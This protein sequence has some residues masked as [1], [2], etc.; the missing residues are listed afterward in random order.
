MLG[1]VHMNSDFKALSLGDS[2]QAPQ[3]PASLLGSWLTPGR[4][5]LILAGLIAAFFPDVLFAGKSF[6]F[7]DFG[8][9]TYPLAHYQRES[10]W[11]GE[12]PLWDPL[13]NCGIPFLAQWNTMVLYPLSLIYILLPL[14][15]GLNIYLLIHLVLAGMGMF[16][17]ASHWTKNRLAAGVAG[18][19]F[20]F[21]GLTL[22]C[23]MWTS[24]IAALAWMPWVV[25]ACEQAGQAG[26]RKQVIIAAL[27]GA[28]QM[29]TG[30][31]EIILFTWF[32]LFALWIGQT[33]QS[34]KLRL[35]FPTRLALIILLVSLLGAAQLLPFLD[36]I[37]HS[38]RNR[39]M[40]AD[41][42]AIPLSGWANL[43]VP[44]FN[45]YKSPLGVYFQ[46]GQ[47]WTSS[48]YL[49]VGTLALG[50]LAIFLVRVPR[51]WL[52]SAVAV[53]GFIVAM[54]ERG[55][56]YPWLLKIFPP[57]GFMRYPVKF[58]LL[59]SFTT[60]LLAAFAIARLGDSSTVRWSTSV[61]WTMSLAMLLVFTMGALVWYAH[62]YPLTNEPWKTVWI[63]GLTRVIFLVLILAT[64]LVYGRIQQLRLQIIMGLLLLTLVWLDVATHA[65]R[66]NPTVE[67]SVY[68]PGLLS[69]QLHVSPG[70]GDGRAFLEKQT[71]DLVYGWM[72]LDP[73]KD[74]LGRRVVLLGDCNLLD[75]I[76]TLAGFFPVYLREPQ[77]IFLD[78]F[79]AA[80]NNFPSGLADF[81]SVSQVT[82]PRRLSDWQFRS[83]HLPFCTMGQKPIFVALSNTPALLLKPDFDPR[84]IVYL[85]PEARTF[86]RATNQTHGSIRSA[87]YTA[88]RL[89]F[90][91]AA[92]APALLVLS[93][94]YYHPWR[95]YLD[96]KPTQIWQ[97]DYAFQALEVP[98][99]SHRVK[100][101]YEDRQF[102]LGVII[103]LT[104]LTGCLI[105][106]CL[107]PRT[108]T[109]P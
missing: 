38:D 14:T 82:N 41:F 59:T 40:G 28:L 90:E 63:N 61:R 15:W 85:P 49:G 102:Y 62:V 43:L 36:L 76:P 20:V 3:L 75:D 52:L 96:D 33:V 89:D 16:L 30:S 103:S 99:G 37:A 48:Y 60:P 2:E 88:H 51:V 12:V 93:Q 42:W 4:F 47:D 23:L 25:L 109:T 54:G 86:V 46:P 19:A 35:R 69:R 17:L 105:F 98:G 106:L 13:N 92:N 84:Q 81:L 53:F 68:Q 97:A 64:V 80:T 5:A 31:P 95:A 79:N 91:V 55:E 74:Y 21:N 34:G 108:T 104:T 101:V 56:L 50:L 66:Q 39:A 29:F 73:Y 57:L 7:R 94:A 26:E 67:A 83:S 10:F 107:R 6:V 70:L 24:N 45:C 72:L 77:T 8:I 18:I 78:I 87:R 58:A 27:T 44:L 65:P 9:F 1:L 32:L 11:Q 100:L 71:H 22:N